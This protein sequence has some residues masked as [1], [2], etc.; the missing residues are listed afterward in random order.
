MRNI[1]IPL[2]SSLIHPVRSVLNIISAPRIFAPHSVDYS[3]C[4]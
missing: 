1:N 2:I 4:P 3:V